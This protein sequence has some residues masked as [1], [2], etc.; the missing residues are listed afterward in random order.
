MD[1]LSLISYSV[2]VLLMIGIVIYVI[3]RLKRHGTLFDD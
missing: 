3:V 2:P 1:R